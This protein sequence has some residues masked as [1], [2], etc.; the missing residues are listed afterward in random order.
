MNSFSCSVIGASKLGRLCFVLAAGLVVLACTTVSAQEKLAITADDF[1]RP[2]G[3][4]DIYTVTGSDGE[5]LGELKDVVEERMKFG[6]TWIMKVLGLFNGNRLSETRVVVTPD[7]ITYYQS[8]NTSRIQ[9]AYPLPMEVG[10]T[11][12]YK[13]GDVT[14]VVRVMGEET[15]RTPAGTFKC[16]V[17]SVTEDGVPIGKAW[18]TPG[19]GSVQMTGVKPRP[20]TMTLKESKNP[21]ALTPPPGWDLFTNYE[22]GTDADGVLFS[23]AELNSFG[24]GITEP[25]FDATEGAGGTAGSLRW[26][27]YVEPGDWVQG[28][29]VLTGEFDKTFD[30]SKYDQ[31][32]FYVKGFRPGKCGLT[33]N[34]APDLMH[35]KPWV[36]LPV[37]Y[38]NEWH[39]V[40]INLADHDFSAMDVRKVQSVSL[41]CLGGE[42]T[43][44]DVV[45]IDELMGHRKE[46]TE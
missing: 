24:K 34:G 9:R 15:I 11:C 26:S 33:I 14:H 1:V 27:Y 44:G 4:Y 41:S 38:S 32:S 39:K 6:T 13:I 2:V 7:R 42:N 3:A 36:F 31:I 20:F 10:K 19:P 45:W 46:A 5:V 25:K 37:E 35:P 22:P 40:T 21:K 29:V 12:T 43:K 23:N 16:L 8:D 17:T 28:G 30:L 18:L